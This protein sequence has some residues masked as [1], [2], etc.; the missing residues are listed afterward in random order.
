MQQFQHIISVQVDGEDWGEFDEYDGGGQTRSNVKRRA[1]GGGET[2]YPGRKTI[3]DV[4][5][6]RPYHLDRDHARVRKLDTSRGPMRMVVTR[7]PT[8][9]N[10]APYGRPRVDS[11]WL[12]ADNAGSIDV[13]AAD[14]VQ[15]LELVLMVES[16]A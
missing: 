10:G 12:G 13:S 2:V 6:R 4:T 7:Q 11:G 16:R 1:P 5:V 9:V 15:I 8:D 3:E 14:A